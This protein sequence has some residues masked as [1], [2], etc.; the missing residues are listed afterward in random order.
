M[1]QI[2]F[3]KAYTNRII[4]NNVDIYLQSIEEY[5]DNLLL[6]QLTS[7]KGRIDAIKR[8]FKF[9]KLIPVYIDNL[10]IFVPINNLKEYENI[11]INA[12]RV[13]KT[14]AKGKSTIVYF[15]DKTKLEVN[16]NENLIIKYISRAIS[17]NH[18][19]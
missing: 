1:K 15:I 3:I 14:A 6:N 12:A 10:N 9:Q 11:Y 4:I 18:N 7:Y 8:K 16:K 13:I 17:I 2:N 5:F 19:S